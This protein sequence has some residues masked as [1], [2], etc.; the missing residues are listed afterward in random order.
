MVEEYDSFASNRVLD[1]VPGLVD[2]P[3]VS[4]KLLYNVKKA[5]DGSVEKHK[6][7]FVAIGFSQVEGIDYNE[8]FAP[9]ERYS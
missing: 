7:R 2:K 4:S 8:N 5:L 6:V 3:T 9:I 1:V